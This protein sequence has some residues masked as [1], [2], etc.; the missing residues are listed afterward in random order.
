MKLEGSL[1]GIVFYD[2]F[3]E[4]IVLTLVCHGDWCG[5]ALVTYADSHTKRRDRALQN[6]AVRREAN[7]TI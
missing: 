2:R 7:A 1:L 3:L 4:L 6:S 5:G